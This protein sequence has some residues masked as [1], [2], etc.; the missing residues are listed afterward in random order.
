MDLPRKGLES[1]V[2]TILQKQIPTILYVSC[3][4]STLAKDLAVLTKQYTIQKVQPLDMFSQT[5]LVET[6][7]YLERK[8]K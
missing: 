4:P 7:V 3:N 6:I 2:N 8:S 1:M 5:P